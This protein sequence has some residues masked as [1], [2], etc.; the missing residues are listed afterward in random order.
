M[1][2]TYRNLLCSFW[3]Q[4]V[5]HLIQAVVVMQWFNIAPKK[6]RGQFQVLPPTVISV[7]RESHDII[8]YFPSVPTMAAKLNPSR[9]TKPFMWEEKGNYPG[10]VDVLLLW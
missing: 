6:F 3:S 8:F 10:D 4:C 5:G 7:P 2:C 9:C 1:L